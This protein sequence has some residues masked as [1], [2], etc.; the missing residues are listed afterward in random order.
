MKYTTARPCDIC[1]QS[2][3][4]VNRAAGFGILTKK[5]KRMYLRYL[6]DPAA[7]LDGLLLLL[8]DGFVEGLPIREKLTRRAGGLC[9]YT[10]VKG[11]KP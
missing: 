8:G 10:S 7:M 6:A 2:Q 1:G 9:L 11:V 4:Y 5:A 3:F